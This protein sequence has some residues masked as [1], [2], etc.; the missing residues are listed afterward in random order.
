[1]NLQLVLAIITALGI[2]LSSAVIPSQL[3]SIDADE[4]ITNTE[5]GL[6][7]ENVG[8]GESV[9]TNCGQNSI[10]SSSAIICGVSPL[11]EPPVGQTIFIVVE[12]C[13][14]IGTVAVTC[15]VT[16]PNTL[17]GSGITCTRGTEGECVIVS[18]VF[19]RINLQC[20]PFPRVGGAPLQMTCTGFGEAT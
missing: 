5:Q 19:G 6:S 18:P 4:S 9:N 14:G 3:N 2:L 17:A 20:D 1:M 8:S 13:A 10:D 11:G 15:E 16:S 7:Q 12:N